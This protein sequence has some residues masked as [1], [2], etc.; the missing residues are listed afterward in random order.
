MRYLRHLF[1]H[2]VHSTVLLK[3][4]II[5]LNTVLLATPPRAKD[6]AKS[7]KWNSRKNLSYIVWFLQWHHNGD[8]RFWMWPVGSLVLLFVFFF[9]TLTSF[10]ILFFILVFLFLLFLLKHKKDKW[11]S[12]AITYGLCLIAG[13]FQ[14]CFYCNFSTE[15]AFTT[16]TKADLHLVKSESQYDNTTFFYF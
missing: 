14:R 13:E 8:S 3:T 12:L 6:F 16:F 7:L 11:H 15:Q 1:R 5:I 2:T 4:L 9:L 10:F